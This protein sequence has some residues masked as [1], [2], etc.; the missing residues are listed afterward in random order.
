MP[1]HIQILE[2]HGFVDVTPDNPS[3][4]DQELLGSISPGQMCVAKDGLFAQFGRDPEA[5]A[6][7]TV[8]LLQSVFD[9]QDLS[10]VETTLEIQ[11]WE[12]P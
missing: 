9:V 2:K 12:P 11:A 1:L 5:A 6:N 3:E 4:E 7:L 8:E 10:L